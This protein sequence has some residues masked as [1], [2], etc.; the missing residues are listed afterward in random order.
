MDKLQFL[1]FIFAVLLPNVRNC[2]ITDYIKAVYRCSILRLS[3]TYDCQ[4]LGGLNVNF[5]SGSG[6]S[7]AS[8]CQISSKMVA[9]LQKH[10]NLTVFKMAAVRHL[11]FIK[12]NF[13]KV[14]AVRRH[15]A[16]PHQISQRSVKPLRR[17]R[18]FCDFYRAMLC[19]RGTSHGPVSVY[20]CLCLS[21]VG[22]LLKRLFVESRRF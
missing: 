5:T 6:D 10:C 11:G 22:V 15:F 17:Y 18:D 4:K 14:R 2:V 12:F 13:L 7:Y 21:Q 9:N 20:L 1:I 16:P 19:I 3:A 8:P